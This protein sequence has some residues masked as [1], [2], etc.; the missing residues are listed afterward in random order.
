MPKH[1]NAEYAKFRAQFIED[2]YDGRDLIEP[3]EELIAMEAWDSA[4]N[5]SNKRDQQL[6]NLAVIERLEEF[7]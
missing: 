5:A 3:N 4:I 1:L 2:Y 7:L 6:N